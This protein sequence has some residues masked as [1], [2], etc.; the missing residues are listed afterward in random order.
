M[1]KAVDIYISGQTSNGPVIVSASK[2]FNDETLEIRIDGR[3]VRFF[4]VDEVGE[5]Q[6][7]KCDQ[8]LLVGDCEAP[9][10]GCNPIRGAE[11]TCD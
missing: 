10:L 3:K 4:F 9:I 11:C 2:L 1:A 7:P 8:C 6:K 5:P